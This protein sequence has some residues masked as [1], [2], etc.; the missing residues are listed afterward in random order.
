MSIFDVIKK[1]FGVDGSALSSSGSVVG[2]D[3]GLSSIKIVQLRMDNNRAVLET[4][5]EIALGPYTGVEVGKVTKLQPQEITQA[6]I[7][8]IKE[9]NV[10]AT[11][12]GI[13]IPFSSSLTSV[14]E[15]P[16]VSPDKLKQMVPL[17]A[18]KYIPVPMDEIMLDWI[19]IP[20][21]P[22]GEDWT[23]A[24]SG[25]RQK[26]DEPE[27]IEVLLVAIHNEILNNYQSISQGANLNVG[28]YEL[29]IFGTIRSV[30]GHGIAP[31]MIIDIGASATKVY[32]VERGMVRASH[33]VN[34]G[35]Q[36]MTLALTRAFSWNF[37]H[38]ER[39]KREQGILDENTLQIKGISADTTRD[40]TG[41]G[42]RETLLSTL[43]RVF[44]EVD[45]VLLQYEKKYNK[46]VSRVVLT[47]GGSSLIGL[48]EYVKNRIPVEIELGNPFA[49]IQTPAFLDDV[50]REIGP[51]FAVAVGVAL[52]RLQ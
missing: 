27:K 12:A 28:F 26:K 7:D 49:K 23:R 34:I 31:I 46:D 20:K 36:D 15:F 43:G 5:G 9:A 19:V 42:V 14:I 16:K 21:D 44:S 1:S 11:A 50:L 47:G 37:E 6:L 48:E 25:E 13:S 33:L 52:R 29:E 3:I 40:S 4:Y 8:L 32:I 24:I 2:I 22:D 38:A 35:S 18:R 39:V 51:E 41:S 45:R 30:L 10:T 17:E